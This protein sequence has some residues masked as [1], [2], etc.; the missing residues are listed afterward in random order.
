MPHIGLMQAGIW[1]AMA[2]R[3]AYVPL[4]GLFII[5]SWGG[6]ELWI[7]WQ[8]RKSLLPAIAAALVSMLMIISWLQVHHWA[9]SITLYQHAI[10]VTVENDVAHNNL[11]AALYQKGEVNA[12]ILHFVEALRIM[13]GYAAAHQNLNAVKAAHIDIDHAIVEMQKLLKLYPQYQALYYNLGNLYRNKGELD[14]AISQYKTA[15]SIQSNFIQAIDALAITYA[16]SG[17]YEKALFLFKEMLKLQ[18]NSA[19]ICYAIACMYAR[20]NKI[21]ESIAWLKQAVK[22]GYQNWDQLKKD[23]NLENIRSSFGYRELI[24]RQ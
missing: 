3:W 7:R 13:P 12:S 17:E 4:I 11:G 24:E 5:I 16:L 18:P 23:K 9:N 1:P 2:D 15:L 20:Q 8:L 14:K 19:D 21:D 22:K 6:Y 10:D